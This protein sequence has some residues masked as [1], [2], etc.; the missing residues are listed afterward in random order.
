MA[1]AIPF[2]GRKDGLL[3]FFSS[4]AEL[5]FVKESCEPPVRFGQSSTFE[6]DLLELCA[7]EQE[8]EF[9][10]V[11]HKKIHPF[12]RL[13]LLRLFFITVL[14]TQQRILQEFQVDIRYLQQLQPFT[15]A[16]VI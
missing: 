1:D 7:P 9:F 15:V 13:F 10:L 6:R 12:S 5:I 11:F 2:V 3:L 14:A 8:N 4:C 16:G